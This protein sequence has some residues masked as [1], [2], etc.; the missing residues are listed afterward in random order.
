M[1]KLEE[2]HELTGD[3]VVSVTFEWLVYGPN[4]K[5]FE[6]AYFRYLEDE[7]LRA[8]IKLLELG[9]GAQ[10]HID[11]TIKYSDGTLMC[12]QLKVID[13]KW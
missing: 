9:N 7:L 12:E 13:T 3:E 11:Y 5:A 8:K 4:F 1:E 10:L 6:S 2:F